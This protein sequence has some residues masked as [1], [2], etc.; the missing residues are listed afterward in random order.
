MTTDKLI[1][2][3]RA[4]CGRIEADARSRVHAIQVAIEVLGGMHKN[5]DGDRLRPS[6]A[7]MI[8]EAAATVRAPFDQKQLAA[9]A[10]ESYPGHADRIERG[11]YAAVD[12]L[13]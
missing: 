3:L 5:G 9:R 11:K 7:K 6:V 12:H 13:I 4:E 2:S 10:T 1:E 8:L